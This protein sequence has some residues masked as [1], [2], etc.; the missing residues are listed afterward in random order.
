MTLLTIV[1]LTPWF[2]PPVNPARA[3]VYI[4]DYPEYI[5]AKDDCLWYAHF[6]GVD[7]GWMYES[8]ETAKKA[9]EDKL[10][11]NKYLAW[12]GLAKDPNEGV[13]MNLKTNDKPL[14]GDAYRLCTVG[15][16]A[17]ANIVIWGHLAIKIIFQ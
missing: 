1:E 7:W 9:E 6:N 10:N 5:K 14:H 12:R 4:V 15:L 13:Q 11:R 2:L 8:I 17:V 16:L 3:G